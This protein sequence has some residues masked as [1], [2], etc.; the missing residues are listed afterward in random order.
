MVL[1]ITRHTSTQLSLSS[2]VRELHLLVD[3]ASDP[4]TEYPSVKVVAVIEPDSLANLVT[5]LSVAECSE[6]QDAYLQCSTILF[7][8][9]FDDVADGNIQQTMPYSSLPL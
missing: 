1:P 7:E 5:N 8:D 2:R 9:R 6:S 4:W 3:N